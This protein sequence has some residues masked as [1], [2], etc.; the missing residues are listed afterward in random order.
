MLTTFI[1]GHIFLSR[2]VIGRYIYAVGGN[3]D[4]ARVSGIRVQQVI[5]L[6]F[7]LS[8]FFSALASVV[9]TAR[10]NA[11]APSIGTGYEFSAIAAVVIGGTSLYGGEGN[12]LG[13]LVGVLLIAVINNALNLLGV[14]AYY[15]DVARGAIIFLAVLFDSLRKRYALAD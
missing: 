13:T 12:L 11:F 14:S 4:A 3:P 5:I 6:T 2:T 9:L 10:L 7:V 8:G 1:F 15:Q